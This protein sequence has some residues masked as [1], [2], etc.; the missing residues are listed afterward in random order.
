MSGQINEAIKTK[1]NTKMDDHL[2][3]TIFSVLQKYQANYAN[4]PAQPEFQKKKQ[5]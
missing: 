2:A 5:P 1:A 3:S 4:F